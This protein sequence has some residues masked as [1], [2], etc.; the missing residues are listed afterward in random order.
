MFSAAG[1]AK[2]MG[3]AVILDPVGAGA[4][5]YRTDTAREFIR[6]FRPA[7]IR[8]NAS[9]IMAV[10]EDRSRTKGVDSTDDSGDALAAAR[11]INESH[12]SAVVISGET[13]F[14]I[15]RNRTVRIRNGHPMM[16]RVTGMGC[17]ASALCGAFSAVG[18]DPVSSAAA[19]MAVMGIAGEMAAGSSDGPGTLQVHF[20]DALYSLSRE[21]IVIRIRLEE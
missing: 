20:L 18:D 13:D 9:E 8:G 21:D 19:A 5:R 16:T 17:T 4:T 7:I 12:G 6:E 3:I 1:Q 14:I 15:G 11:E 2:M 10:Q